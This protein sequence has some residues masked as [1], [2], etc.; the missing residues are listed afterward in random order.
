MTVTND[1]AKRGV[2]LIEEFNRALTHTE[3]QAQYLLQVVSE[4]CRRQSK[5]SE[6]ALTKSR[7]TLKF[8]VNTYLQILYGYNYTQ[9]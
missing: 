1:H 9:F 2:A 5:Q 6:E 3:Q 8:C 4:Q 7:G